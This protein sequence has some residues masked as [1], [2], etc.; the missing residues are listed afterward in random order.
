MQIS[1]VPADFNLAMQVKRDIEKD[2]SRASQ[3]MKRFPRLNNGLYSDE[4][5]ASLDWQDAKEAYSRAF[6]QQRAYNQAF[7]R[8]H[9]KQYRKNRRN[10]QYNA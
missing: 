2:V 5:R 1:H 10:L 6:A 9:G 4:T 8:V 7:L 3:N